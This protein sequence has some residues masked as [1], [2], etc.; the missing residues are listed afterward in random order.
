MS[1]YSLFETGGWVMWA[2]LALSIAALA[3]AAERSVVLAR[4]QRG[5][6]GL[7]FELKRTLLEKRSPEKARKLCQPNRGPV[8]RL[9]TAGL[10]RLNGSSRQLEATL[11]RQAQKEL[12]RLGRG[13]RVLATVAV[14]APLLGFLGT[15]TGMIAAFDALVKAGSANPALV[16]EGIREALTTTAAGLVVA[17]PAQL[18]YSF[19]TSRLDKITGHLEETS[20]LL[21]EVREDLA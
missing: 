8:A 7:L 19:L 12:R 13:L 9:A 5:S 20:N 16:A 17:V 14:T 3:T 1:I 18:L 4:A 10:T 2:L 11:E 6:G 15:V 21:L